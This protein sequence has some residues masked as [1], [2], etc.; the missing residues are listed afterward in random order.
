MLKWRLLALLGRFRH[1]R[2]FRFGWARP[3]RCPNHVLMRRSNWSFATTTT[4]LP[5]WS[6][7]QSS[8]LMNGA[9][10]RA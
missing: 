3:Y 2:Y 7:T 9:P 1:L 8:H 5:P 4:Y 6:F 10:N